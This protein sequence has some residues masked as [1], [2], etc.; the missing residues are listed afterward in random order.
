MEPMLEIKR[1]I[2]PAPTWHYLGMNESILKGEDAE[3]FAR[4]NQEEP[5]TESAGIAEQKERMLHF[6]CEAEENKAREVTLSAEPGS[7]LTVW[8]EIDS[9]KEGT[10]LFALTTQINA[11]KGAKVRLIQVQLLGAHY[12]FV[13]DVKT[14]GED[15]AE[16]EILQL[17]LGGQKTWAE[18]VS[19]L[20]GTE[21]SLTADIGYWCRNTQRLDMNA[22]VLHKATHTKSRI[23]TKGVLED[24]AFKLFRGTIDFKNGASG[25]EGEETEEVL[26]LGEDAVNQ[27]IP[28]I[29]CGEE[30]VQGNHGATIGEPDEDILFYM[31]SRGIGKEAATALLAKAKIEGLKAKLGN[32]ALEE[33]VQNYLD[34]VTN[35]AGQ[36]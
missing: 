20:S 21:S 11:G 14:E 31:A 16:I 1:N 15:Q 24:Q 25:S 29:L 4:A 7:S 3:R 22:V 9:P 19:D 23:L 32:A 35:Y 5:L 34:E 30:D 17:F 13:N 8:M 26:M 18:L 12:R 36:S 2:L 33:K 27:T 28:L 10:G 6:R